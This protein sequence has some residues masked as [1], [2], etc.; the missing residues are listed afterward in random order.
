[1]AKLSEISRRLGL[2]VDEK[3]GATEITDITCRSSECHDGTIFAALCGE[4]FDGHDFIPDAYEHGA[5]MFISERIV[6]LPDDAVL[7]VVDDSRSALAKA[8]AVVFGD[9][10]K[11]LKIIGVTGTKGKSTVVHI[12]KKILDF[13]GRKAAA[14][15]TVGMYVGDEF[16]PTENSTPES[17]VIMKFLRRAVDMGAEYAVIEVSS[18]GVKQKRVD[19]IDFDIGVL[20]NISRD[21]IGRGEHKNFAEYK[22]CKKEFFSRAKTKILN[23]DDKYYPEFSDAENSV[24]YGIS[25]GAKIN[26][27]NIKTSRLDNAFCSVFD[28]DACGKTTKITIS[29]PGRFAVY[30]ALAAISACMT[31]GVS[32]ETCRDAIRDFSMPGRFEKIDV[33]RDVD[34][35]ID[36][37]HNGD[38]MKNALEA[39]RELAK[40]RVICVFGSVGGRT[41]M[42][43]AALGKA[44]GKYADLC[45]VTSDNPNFENPLDICKDIAINIKGAEYKIIPDREAAL[46]YA[47]DTAEDGDFILISGKGHEKYQLVRGKKEPFDERE[48]LKSLSKIKTKI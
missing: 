6:S 21:H 37:A 7:L 34:V 40:G 13:S 27:K 16:Q 32:P 39:A 23:S 25:N 28:L 15:S 22:G 41:K 20:T 1:M 43:R 35:V 47:L 2:F 18:Q 24:T 33:G 38:S 8:A 30:D 48:I 31:L 11:N 44:A 10:Q 5:R 26:A 45:I 9:P 12:I 4:R 17:H 36:Y 29:I 46:K 42:R 14:V 3:V 19:A